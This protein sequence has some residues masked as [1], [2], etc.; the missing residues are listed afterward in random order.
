MLVTGGAGQL[1]KM[2]LRQIDTNNLYIDALT[3]NRIIDSVTNIRYIHADLTQ[4]ETLKVLSTNYDVIV[5]CASNPKD[6]DAVDIEGTRNLLKAIKGN[7][8]R[9]F[10]Y[11]SIVGVDKSTY[12]YYQNKLK[13]EQLIIGSGIPYTILRITQFHDFVNN[14]ILNAG[15]R[16]T[17]FLTIPEGLKFQSIDITDVC[18][19]IKEL[20]NSESSNSILDIG[21]PE[22]LT[23][24]NI[25]EAYQDIIK[26]NK[27][28]KMTSDLNDFQKLFTTGINLS[29]ERKLGRITWRDYLLN[30]RMEDKFCASNASSLKSN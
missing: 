25:V 14:R 20:I 11:I 16:E 29:P 22:I 12:T 7:N 6:S 5:H 24:Q 23:I 15:E 28:I 1:G 3:R 30:K 17:E 8:I 4:Y 19:N 13:A 2:L 21:G 9:N 26:P 10:V 27:K 18:E